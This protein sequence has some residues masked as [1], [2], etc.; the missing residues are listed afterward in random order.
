MEIK[1]IVNNH[2][3][4]VQ[5]HDGTTEIMKG[6]RLRNY[7]IVFRNQI[8][9]DYK[10]HTPEKPKKADEKPKP[11]PKKKTDSAPT[12]IINDSQTNLN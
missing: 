7:L 8:K 1:D 5:K 4:E 11:E 12:E 6:D 9:V 10:K 2:F 3:Y